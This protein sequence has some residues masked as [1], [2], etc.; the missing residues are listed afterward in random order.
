MPL[1]REEE[2]IPV[3]GQHGHAVVYGRE[4]VHQALVGEFV[5][6]VVS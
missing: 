1:R 3:R 2:I 6:G 4:Q 5:L